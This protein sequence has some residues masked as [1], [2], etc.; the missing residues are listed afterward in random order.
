MGAGRPRDHDPSRRP[1]GHAAVHEPRAGPRPAG[2]PGA[3]TCSSFGL[4]LQE[5]VTGRPAVHADADGAELARRLA[6]AETLPAEG[7]DT[8]LGELID[9][10]AE[11]LLQGDIHPSAVAAAERLRWMRAK[12]RRR[13]RRFAAAAFV[14]VLV[15][16]TVVSVIGFARASRARDRAEVINTFLLDMLA[17]A[18]PYREG[19]DARVVDVLDQAAARVDREFANHPRDRAAVLYTLGSSYRAIGES[20]RAESPLPASLELRRELPR[21]SACRDPVLG[22]PFA[23]VAAELGRYDEAEA[24]LRET[25]ETCRNGLG[26]DHLVT[27]QTAFDLGQTLDLAG[28]RDRGRGTVA[29]DARDRIRRPR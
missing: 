10:A 15:V 3:R 29:R 13:V 4:L 7:I 24:L 1:D 22:G 5:L 21:S 8:H 17:S 16:S 26:A 14:A 23:G 28:H 20:A 18:D 11:A 27:L 19:V 9:L 6:W 2:G 25:F 12:P